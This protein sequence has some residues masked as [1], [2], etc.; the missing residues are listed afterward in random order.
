ML[1]CQTTGTVAKRFRFYRDNI[2]AYKILVSRHEL[3]S[4]NSN[5]L[6]SSLALFENTSIFFPIC[7]DDVGR[8]VSLQSVQ[9]SQLMGSRRSESEVWI[10]RDKC[11]TP[12]R[13]SWSTRETWTD[14]WSKFIVEFSNR[15]ILP[16]L[17]RFPW[18]ASATHCTLFFVLKT[19]SLWSLP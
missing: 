13:F 16:D 4:N 12:Q 18:K 10:S 3:F 7:V 15:V 9:W 14:W 2:P 8:E 6:Y 11:T 1:L 5:A 17:I 19:P